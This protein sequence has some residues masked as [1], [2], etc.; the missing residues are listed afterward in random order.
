MSNLGA[1]ALVSIL[2]LGLILGG[3]TQYQ[4]NQLIDECQ[5]KLPRNEYCEIIAVPLKSR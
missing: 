1:I 2:L 3:V 5:S 4:R